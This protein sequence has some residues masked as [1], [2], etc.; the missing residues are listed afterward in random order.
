MQLVRQ[1]TTIADSPLLPEYNALNISRLLALCGLIGCCSFS[2]SVSD[3]PRYVSIASPTEK[4]AVEAVALLP[5]LLLGLLTFLLVLL[6]LLLVL[7][8]LPTLLLVLLLD[9][10]VLL[11][12]VVDANVGQRLPGRGATNVFLCISSRDESGFV[13]ACRSCK[14]GTRRL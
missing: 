5:V 7:L 6:G 8:M 4:S 9:L 3:P 1:S 14:R 12:L 11:V 2:D 13:G 10:L